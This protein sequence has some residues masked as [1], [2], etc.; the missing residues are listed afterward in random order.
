VVSGRNAVGA[1]LAE[2]KNFVYAGKFFG[3][4]VCSDADQ[5]C[6]CMCRK[7]SDGL[8]ID[9]SSLEIKALQQM[10]HPT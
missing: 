6:Y 8:L 10:E 1:G 3:Q 7:H 2:G 4:S 5:N 9:V